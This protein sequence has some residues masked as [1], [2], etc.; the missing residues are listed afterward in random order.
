MNP[1]WT[2]LTLTTFAWGSI[3]ARWPVAGV[4]LPVGWSVARRV[5]SWRRSPEATAVA[6][7]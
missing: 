5:A 2:A 7:P 6:G 4:G 1:M 3:E